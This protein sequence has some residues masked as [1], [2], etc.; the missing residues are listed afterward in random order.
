VGQ[1]PYKLS[2][3]EEAACRKEVEEGL[4]SG[5]IVPSTAPNGCPVM[6]ADKADGSLRMCVNYKKVNAVTIARQAIL[7]NIDDVLASLPPNGSLFTKID[8]KGAYHLLRMDPESEDLTTF[9]TKFG[10]FKYKVIPFGLQNAPGHFQGRMNTIFHDLIG[11]GMWAYIDDI[12]VYEQDL[13]KHRRLVNE[14]LARL[15][16]HGLIAN[17]DKCF[18]ETDSVDFLGFRLSPRGLEMQSPKL[19]P[20]LEFP[21]PRTVKTLQSFLGLCNYYRG[22]IPNYSAMILPLL[23]LLKKD[24]P[25]DFDKDCQEAFG[26]LK[27]AF[28]LEQVLLLP[29]RN[30]QFF[31]QCDA[32]DFAI[33]AALHQETPTGMRPISFYSRKLTPAEINYPVWDKELLAIKDALAQWRHLLVD[34]ALPVIIETDHR[35]LTFF[36]SAQKLNRRQARWQT[37]FA[38]FN[39]QLIYI[40]GADNVVAD[41]LSRRADLSTHAGDPERTVNESILLPSSRF[42]NALEV[43]EESAVNW[44]EESPGSEVSLAVNAVDVEEEDG[45]LAPFEMTAGNIFSLNDLRAAPQGLNDEAEA[46]REPGQTDVSTWP[47][48]VYQFLVSGNIDADLPH[49]Y[50]FL[51]RSQAKRFAVKD[52]QLLR[53]L[54]VNGQVLAVPYL[55]KRFRDRKMKELHE[56]MGHLKAPSTLDALRVR[57][58]WP[59]VE[60]DYK[61][62]I[63]RCTVCQMYEGSDKR[64]RHPMH[65]LQDPGIP[66]HTWHV[67]FIQDMEETDEGWTQIAVATDRA[68][69]MSLAKASRTRDAAAAIT[70]LQELTFRFGSPSVIITDRASAF[71]S[72]QFQAFLSRNGIRHHPSTSYH[73]QTNG[74][75]ERVNGILEKILAKMC[76]GI[77]AKWG[78]Y[79]SA[80]VFNLNARKHTVTGFSPFFLA[81]GFNPRLPGDISP[82]QVFDITQEE[83]RLDATTRE[84]TL[85]GQ[86][87]A[88]AFLRSQKQAREMAARHDKSPLVQ[89]RPFVVGEFVKRMVKRLPNQLTR[90]LEPVWQGPFIIDGIGP[91]DSYRL[92]ALNG[93]LEK[94]PVNRNHLEPYRGRTDPL[95]NEP[96]PRAQDL[97]PPPR[98]DSLTSRIS[99]PQGDA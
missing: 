92:K 52:A 71:L 19:Q 45:V 1:A 56:A 84:L 73:P 17:I 68:T 89:D 57:W 79:L 33:G 80:A 96:R 30:R 98:R 16:V 50:A 24:V 75:V 88:A 94:H 61:D 40:P 3:K 5:K 77:R 85:L 63:Q 66:F 93:E 67:D 44:L 74:M 35:N 7:P 91:H 18:F 25:F 2:L 11:R 72:D 6:F 10:K 36:R 97:I 49:R 9:V 23:R 81:F 15:R 69:R 13:D 51:V 21:P 8:L 65:P 42:V 76:G 39:F 54:T 87:R 14:I 64:I 59:T 29:D 78:K 22:F 20:I 37:F 32:S 41:A 55:P 48:H 95:H 62:F 31:L 27:K 4:K 53:K 34:T 47:I 26:R 86:A 83:E 46:L 43:V 28:V 90:K 58:W 12:L 70:F 99:G 82:I 38:D 60:K